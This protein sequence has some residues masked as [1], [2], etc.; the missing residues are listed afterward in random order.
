M[1]SSLYLRIKVIV[2]IIMMLTVASLKGE[3]TAQMRLTYCKGEVQTSSKIGKS[4]GGTVSAA[5]LFPAEMI[6]N[7]ENVQVT[8]LR[9]GLASKLNVSSLTAWVRNSLSGENLA[10]KSL[11]KAE[12]AKGWNEIAFDTPYAIA[13]GED[14]YV[15][16]TVVLSGTSYPIS[17][18]GDATAGAFYFNDEVWVDNSNDGCLSIEAVITADNLPKYNLSL[19]QTSI[20][21]RIYRNVETPI[22]VS[23][24]NNGSLDVS[25]FDLVCYIEGMEPIVN[26]IA[27]AL[28]PGETYNYTFS[29]IPT[30][31]ENC[32]ELPVTLSIQEIKD[33]ADYDESD[34]TYSTNVEYLKYDYTHK[35]LLEEF[36]TEYCSNCP[37]AASII[38]TALHTQPYS[39]YVLAVCHHAGYM[40][41]WLTIPADQEYLWLGANAAPMVM[42]DRTPDE[43][44][45]AMCSVVGSV[46]I[47]SAKFDAKLA[48]EAH[49]AIMPSASYDADSGLI[50]VNIH[51][52]KDW[53]FD[54]E[55]YNIT[56]FLI[57]NNIEAHRQSGAGTSKAFIHNHV[58][59]DVNST[60]GD[61]ISWNSDDEFDYS[62]QFQYDESW[63][64]EDMEVIAIV[65]KKTDTPSDC[66]VE[67][68]ARCDIDFNTDSICTLDSLD[69]ESV[70]YY[71]VCGNK[72][73][74][75]YSGIVIKVTRFKNG[76]KNVVK[77]VNY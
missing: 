3:T 73:P 9:I 52:A 48:V 41:D 29:F 15:G 71:D 11:E 17:V 19:T 69:I 6:A 68:A 20:P 27:K 60:W 5:A 10:E 57:E 56:V 8:N 63:K 51:G 25:G 24:E 47:M 66:M 33:G 75:N 61:A 64:Q 50:T 23:I 53:Y 55:D 22:S 38:N 1:N 21:E 26:N 18:V 12:I 39:D 45:G 67:N 16:Y 43:T 58:N 42:Y 2:S 4:G 44:S 74:A 13:E 49:C 32:R 62:C 28:T 36:T 72:V 14:L 30:M 70:V 65:N 37:A 34:N 31:E 59:R 76:L 77:I 46:D 40:T 54:A 35:V 7:Y